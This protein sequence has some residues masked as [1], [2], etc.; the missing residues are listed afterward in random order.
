MKNNHL[1]VTLY[2]VVI[3]VFLI[4]SQWILS[5]FRY[6]LD[7]YIYSSIL[8]FI[9]LISFTFVGF[10]MGLEH[11]LEQRKITGKWKFNIY[12]LSLVVL[13]LF[14]TSYY[15]F[16]KSF[17]LFAYINFLLLGNIIN[18]FAH[19][20]LQQASSIVLGYIIVTSFYK[21]KKS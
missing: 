17:D 16:L 19:T 2:G 5:Y 13:P 3:F 1:I 14:I 12:K 7:Q 15:D 21:V 10:L 8:Y 11:F 20:S 4:T 9:T 18:P 6:S